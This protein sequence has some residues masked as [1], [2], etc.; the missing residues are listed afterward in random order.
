[1][2]GS[3]N[4]KVFTISSQI[5]NSSKDKILVLKNCVCGGKINDC[6]LNDVLSN[7]IEKHDL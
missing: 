1:M 3:T 2:Y 5:F 6:E 4:G 7:C